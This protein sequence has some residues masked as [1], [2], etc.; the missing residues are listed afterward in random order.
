MCS[1]VRLTTEHKGFL[2]NIATKDKLITTRFHLQLNK[3][4]EL[5]ST[6]KSERARTF[7][8]FIYNNGT[9]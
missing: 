1:V 3:Q 6:I 4:N 7:R 8:C 9:L 5:P 2:V